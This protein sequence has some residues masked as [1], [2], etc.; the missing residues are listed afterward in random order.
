MKIEQ[1][2]SLNEAPTTKQIGAIY[3]LAKRLNYDI[4]EP[5]MPTTR[6]EARDL[7]Y[8]LLQDLRKRK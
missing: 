3:R 7:I 8:Q 1:E 5:Y 4:T 6:W 2:D